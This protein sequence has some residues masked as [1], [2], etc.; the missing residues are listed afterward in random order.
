MKTLCLFAI[1]AFT[2][3]ALAGSNS[4]ENSGRAHAKVAEK[5]KARNLAGKRGAVGTQSGVAKKRNIGRSKR[6]Q[7]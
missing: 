3:P 7:E 1:L 6:V 4:G 2:A 5:A